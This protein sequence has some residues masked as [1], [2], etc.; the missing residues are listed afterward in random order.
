MDLNSIFDQFG[1]FGG[2][3]L[4][5]MVG[6]LSGGIYTRGAY[7]ALE[8]DRDSYRA[9]F[10]AQ[11]DANIKIATSLD[12]FMTKYGSIMNHFINSLPTPFDS[13]NTV[14]PENEDSPE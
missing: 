13:K 8:R 11:R 1:I 7:K 9:N 10:E 4:L 5:A 3:A 6:I 14:P 12:N 2:I